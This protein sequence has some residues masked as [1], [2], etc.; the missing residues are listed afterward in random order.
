MRIKV[1]GDSAPFTETKIL[2]LNDRCRTK[3]FLVQVSFKKG[4]YIYRLADT[5]PKDIVLIVFGTGVVKIETH[6]PRRK[7][8]DK[9]KLRALLREKGWSASFLAKKAALP[10]DTVRKLSTF[11]STRYPRPFTLERVAR[12]L[13]VRKEAILK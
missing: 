13:G 1:R 5:F 2:A 10:F 11:G 3:E 12:A 7:E 9:V 8:I 4:F 6:T